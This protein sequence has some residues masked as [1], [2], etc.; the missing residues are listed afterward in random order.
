MN[1]STTFSLNKE[2]L[3]VLAKNMH[4]YFKEWEDNKI[5]L[6][7]CYKALSRAFGYNSW[8]HLSAFLKKHAEESK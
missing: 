3:K 7:H 4:E 2:T 8:N 6:T 1:E 5:K